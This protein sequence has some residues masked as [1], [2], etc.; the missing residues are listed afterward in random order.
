MDS[1]CTVDMLW[2]H[3]LLY[4]HVQVSEV[5]FTQDRVMKVFLSDSVLTNDKR[6]IQRSIPEITM[7]KQEAFGLLDN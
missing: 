6:R 4:V 5:V 3:C 2:K 7:P 1:I